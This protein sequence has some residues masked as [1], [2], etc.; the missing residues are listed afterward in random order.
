MS[1]VLERWRACTIFTSCTN[2]Q[3]AWGR[4][5]KDKSY[6]NTMQHVQKVLSYWSCSLYYPFP[7][8][9][10]WILKQ[11]YQYFGW[12]RNIMYVQR[13][14]SLLALS[15]EDVLPAV[16]LCTNKIAADHENVVGLSPVFIFWKFWL[17]PSLALM[18]LEFQLG[19]CKIQPL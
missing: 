14:Y 19:I 11:F 1:S 15:P 8:F 5:R 9:C 18:R 6:F 3:P 4:E 13:F 7:L 10:F 16:Y 17:S 12:L 2:L